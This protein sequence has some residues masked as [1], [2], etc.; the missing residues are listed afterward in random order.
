MQ[1]PT[2][3]SKR[4]RDQSVLKPRGSP[5][6]DCV[7]GHAV[8][9]ASAS[10]CRDPLER[11]WRRSRGSSARER[12]CKDAQADA[13]PAHRFLQG[14]GLHPLRDGHREAAL[15]RLHGQGGAAPHL[16]TPRSVSCRSRPSHLEGAPAPR[17]A[18][19]L[20]GTGEILQGGGVPGAAAT[21]CPH[22]L[23]CHP[24]PPPP[25]PQRRPWPWPLTL[26]TPSHLPRDPHGR[27][28]ARCDG[29]VGVPSL[30]LPPVPPPAAPQ[31]R[32]QVAPP[33]RSC[34]CGPHGP[35]GKRPWGSPRPHRPELAPSSRRLDP[36]G[37]NL[38]SS[39]LL[40]S[41]L[42][43][44]RGPAGR[45]LKPQDFILAPSPSPGPGLGLPGTPRPPA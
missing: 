33:P 13:G 15:P 3:Q 20:P 38:L 22:L 42:P 41:V 2:L 17:P 8:L 7:E 36:D 29:P 24:P 43:A 32:S 1:T 26:P 4:G 19:T 25:P 37:I 35:S 28:V 40:V 12:G 45:E 16:P 9:G 18:R 5:N 39:L 27:D 34:P 10:P 23:P 14:C 6:G 21:L 44:G 30:Q 11:P 31:P